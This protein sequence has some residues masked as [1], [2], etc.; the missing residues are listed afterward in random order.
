MENKK[1]EHLMAKIIRKKNNGCEIPEHNYQQI[2][3]DLI[4]VRALYLLKKLKKIHHV[5]CAMRKQVELPV[6][7]LRAGDSDSEMDVYNN[8]CQIKHHDAGY[9]STHYVIKTSSAR[10][11]L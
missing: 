5:I 3:T 7:Y 8:R 2:I 9:R 6:V 4:G 11:K 10:E 1:P